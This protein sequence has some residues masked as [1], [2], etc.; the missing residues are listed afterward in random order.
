MMQK[1]QF[2]VFC[3]NLVLA[4]L[5]HRLSD[6]FPGGWAATFAYGFV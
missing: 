1:D 3:D 2:F 4:S 6:S 5:T